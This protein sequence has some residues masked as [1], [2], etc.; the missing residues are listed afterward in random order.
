MV[1][2]CSDNKCRLDPSHW[3]A[4]DNWPS[5]TKYIVSRTSTLT[6]LASWTLSP[7][8]LSH[9]GQSGLC[10]GCINPSIIYGRHM[11]FFA[12]MRALFLLGYHTAFHHQLHH[13]ITVETQRK[14]GANKR[15]V[16]FIIATISR[17][18]FRNRWPKTWLIIIRWR[19]T[20]RDSIMEF[21]AI[22]T[23]HHHV[24]LPRIRQEEKGAGEVVPIRYRRQC[25]TSWWPGKKR[26]P[27]ARFTA[28][29]RN[30]I[31]K[32]PLLVAAKT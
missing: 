20:R 32:G 25:D 31:I 24:S 26:S 8:R 7:L 6:M 27:L 4:L 3:K 28:F 11:S 21:Y 18:R 17:P 10:T 1:I 9:A 12:R 14:A 5:E 16:A 22:F 30:R 29:S 15:I 23:A 19:R 2:V 13:Q